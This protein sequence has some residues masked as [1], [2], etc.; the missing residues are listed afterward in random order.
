M[1]GGAWDGSSCITTGR[2]INA[3]CFILQTKKHFYVGNYQKVGFL[4]FVYTW[5]ESELYRR[6]FLKLPLFNDMIPHAF[7]VLISSCSLKFTVLRTRR[8]FKFLCFPIHILTLANFYRIHSFS[9]ENRFEVIK[10]QRAQNTDQQIRI[11]YRCY[12]CQTYFSFVF[13][14]SKN[15]SKMAND[16]ERISYWSG[17]IVFAS[18]RVYRLSVILFFWNFPSRNSYSN[19]RLSFWK[20]FHPSQ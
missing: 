17:K 6:I 5:V 20:I 11:C 18:F 12:C 4:K 13:F 15:L 19:P 16:V 7:G 10:D 2:K 14:E 3:G 9:R 1:W 8:G